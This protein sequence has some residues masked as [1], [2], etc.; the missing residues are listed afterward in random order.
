MAKA[1]ACDRCGNLFK[2]SEHEDKVR[3]LLENGNNFGITFGNTQVY[4]SLCPKC[5]T[6]FQ[7]W[8][9]I[10]AVNKITEPDEEDE[11]E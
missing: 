5:R 2:Q 1:Y 11:D 10:D 6:G 9:D 3:V 4:I 7:K 8:W